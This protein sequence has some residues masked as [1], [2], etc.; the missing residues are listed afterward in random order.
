MS[1]SNSFLLNDAF[2]IHTLE[3]YK[4]NGQTLYNKH[5]YKMFWIKQGSGIV[6]TTR[7][8]HAIQAGYLYCLHSTTINIVTDTYID[9]YVMCLSASFFCSLQADQS[10]TFL[11]QMLFEKDKNNALLISREDAREAEDVLIKLRNEFIASSL[12]KEEIIKSLLKLF[13]LYMTR[14]SV[15]GKA[16][17]KTRETALTESFTGLLA[18][19]I[20]TQ[21][22]VSD[23]AKA[24]YVT[25]GYLNYAVKKAS[26]YTASYHIQQQ[27]ITQA[28]QKALCS[29]YS[30]K[31]IAYELGFEDIAH[32]SKFFKNNFGT[33][34]TNFKKSLIYN[35]L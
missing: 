21:K 9:G 27:I 30:M 4:K 19:N 32:F 3:F 14:K 28:R 11:L 31:E 23:Y 6:H 13:I 16:F 12:L 35:Q 7:G 1:N 26:G 18:K 17:S 5:P 10:F 8:Y 22:K 15:S 20:I 29:D 2:E 33:N 25:P 34:F 24:L